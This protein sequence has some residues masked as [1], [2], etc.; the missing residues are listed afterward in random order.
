MVEKQEVDKSHL[1]SQP[2]ACYQ[3]DKVISILKRSFPAPRAC[4]RWC[5]LATRVSQVFSD[6]GAP[7][8]QA[9]YL[10]AR[11]REGAGARTS[12]TTTQ[13]RALG[14]AAWVWPGL[15]HALQR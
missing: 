13:R 1:Y 10:G 7:V 2:W 11:L 8:T 4:D 14:P 9:S 15:T 3:D 12:L 5:H 6:T